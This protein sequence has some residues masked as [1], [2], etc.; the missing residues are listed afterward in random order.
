MRHFKFLFKFATIVSVKISAV[1]ISFNEEKNIAAAI[2]SV[3]WADEIVVVD[4]ES[5]DRT[6]EIATGLGARVIERAWPG[7]SAQKQFGADNAKYDWIFSLDADER[8]STE[9]AAAVKDLRSKTQIADGYR[10]PRQTT[11]MGRAIRHCGWYPNRQMRLFDRRK[12]KWNEALVHESIEMLHGAPVS[13]L[14]GDI[15]H[16]TVENIAE[17]HSMIG[18]RYAPLGAQQMFDLG[19]RTT[20]VKASTSGIAAFIKVY[21]LKLGFLDGFPGFCIAWFA[22]HNTFMKHAFL[23]EMQNA[24]KPNTSKR[25]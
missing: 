13:D 11:Y 25:L 17:H 23:I 21:F 6:R 4:S 22:A 9:L 20:L 10:I 24:G 14:S 19:R 12:A 7:F 5:T 18:E 2:N 1:I 8:V 3:A 15:L 16:F